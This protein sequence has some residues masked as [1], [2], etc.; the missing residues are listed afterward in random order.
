MS[1]SIF[2]RGGQKAEAHGTPSEQQF[3][4]AHL[5]T[6][7]A[8]LQKSWSAPLTAYV[9]IVPVILR[10]S[11]LKLHRQEP[12]WCISSH[13][14]LPPPSKRLKQSAAEQA[15]AKLYR[16]WW[17]AGLHSSM[18]N[19]A[20][21]VM[22]ADLPRCEVVTEEASSSEAVLSAKLKNFPAISFAGT[23]GG[24]T[25]PNDLKLVYDVLKPNKRFSKGNPDAPKLAVC[26]STGTNIP[27]CSIVQHLHT[28]VAPLPL[29]FARVS[30][31]E[32]S[33]HTACC[34]EVATGLDNVG[35]AELTTGDSACRHCVGS[36]EGSLGTGEGS[37]GSGN[38]GYVHWWQMRQPLL[39]PETTKK[40]N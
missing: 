13:T 27:S 5:E 29:Q 31:G 1:G 25:V 2:R 24:V 16:Q 7:L 3:S 6:K 37:L 9:L 23:C 40:L 22:Q 14:S 26:L 35:A 19:P 36:D 11:I 8:A 39:E 10:S 32:V 4:G 17:P 38:T 12:S 15:E 33:F 20:T 18:W 28:V 30:G 21:T 34:T